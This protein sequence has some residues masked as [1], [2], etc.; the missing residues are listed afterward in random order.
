MQRFL[1]GS[2]VLRPIV[3]SVHCGG[4]T[5]LRP[6]LIQLHKEILEW[7]AEVQDLADAL[8]DKDEELEEMR[9][10]NVELRENMMRKQK[11]LREVEKGLQTLIHERNE[12]IKQTERCR[13]FLA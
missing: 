9:R 13:S 4:L 5:A 6:A 11:L 2:L 1:P 3:R 12:A 10:D 8:A 7:K